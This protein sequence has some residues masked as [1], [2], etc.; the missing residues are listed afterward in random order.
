MFGLKREWGDRVRAFYPRFRDYPDWK[1][2]QLRVMDTVAA[3]HP[4]EPDREAALRAAVRDNVSDY[5]LGDPLGYAGM[6]AGKVSRLWLNYSVGTVHRQ[7]DVMRAV[8]IALVLAAFAG[9]VAG[10]VA[11]RGREP[12][13]WALA[14]VLAW[15]TVINIVLVSEARHNLPVMPVLAAGGAAGAALAVRQRSRTRTVTDRPSTRPDRPI[16]RT[17]T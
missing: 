9:L 6:A 7:Q 8:H 12:G 13:L 14:I 2:P 10:L 3:T 1:L 5:V 16:A 4:E 15:V 11:R 17:A